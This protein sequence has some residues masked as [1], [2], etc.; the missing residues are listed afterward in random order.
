MLN[1]QYLSENMRTKK[2]IEQIEEIILYA[3]Q[4][5]T[6]IEESLKPENIEKSF[7]DVKCSGGQTNPDDPDNCP[8]VCCGEPGSDFKTDNYLLSLPPSSDCPTM[9]Q[10]CWWKQFSKDLTKVG[11]L[12][13]P[14]GLPPIEDAKYFLTQGP[15]IRLG[16]KYWP[17]GYL[18][19]SFIP[20]PI[21]NPIDG[22]PFIR[23]PLPMIWTIINPI[24]SKQKITTIPKA[25]PSPLIASPLQFCPL[26]L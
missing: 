9:F 14:N 1:F 4:K 13:Y 26:N 20:I 11:L 2:K 12:P 5:R 24:V 15:S 7:S 17:V 16:L 10:K 25:K 22:Q 19:P 8:P 18:P 21:P 6:E 3:A 23:I